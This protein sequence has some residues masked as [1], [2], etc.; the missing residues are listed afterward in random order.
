MSAVCCEI[1][2]QQVVR[3]KT[4]GCRR[5]SSIA[6]ESVGALSS[7]FVAALATSFIVHFAPLRLLIPH[8]RT[9]HNMATGK[10]ST[11]YEASSKLARFPFEPYWPEKA[12]KICITGA[13]G[14]IAR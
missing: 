1:V 4:W 8:H 10:V 11:T 12:L 9:H 7:S 13:G 5:P 3:A 2:G 6:E 14:F